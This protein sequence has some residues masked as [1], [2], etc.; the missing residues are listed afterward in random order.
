MRELALRGRERRQ[1]LLDPGPAGGTEHGARQHVVLAH[2]RPHRVHR[3]GIEREPVGQAQSGPRH[4]EQEQQL[5]R[6]VLVEEVVRGGLPAQLPKVLQQTPHLDR[7]QVQLVFPDVAIFEVG[8][9]AD[10]LIVGHDRIGARVD[11]G[12]AVDGEQQAVVVAGDGAV[13]DRVGEQPGLL[14]LAGAIEAQQ[15]VAEHRGRVVQVGRGEDQG[16]PLGIDRGEPVRQAR[17]GLLLQPGGVE[18]EHALQPMVPGRKGALRVLRLIAR[19]RAGK[20]RRERRLELGLGVDLAVRRVEEAWAVD[21]AGRGGA[22]Q[23]R[24][25]VAEIEPLPA[26]REVLGAGA[27][28]QLVKV[29]GGCRHGLAAGQGPARGQ[30]RDEVAGALRPPRVGGRHG[31]R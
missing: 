30:G 23:T 19:G 21:Q 24:A 15:G 5:V 17:A 13:V 7:R 12:Q 4:I 6:A 1:T 20:E 8:I 16:D 2:D 31:L 14:V 3:D 28:D 18:T 29:V 26:A 10:Q 22:Q 9:L 25:I 11:A 27:R